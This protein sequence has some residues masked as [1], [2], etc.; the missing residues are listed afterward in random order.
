MNDVHAVLVPLPL[1]SPRPHQLSPSA[2]LKLRTYL[3]SARS[4][5]IGASRYLQ[6]GNSRAYF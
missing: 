5:A 4:S 2:F 1:R 6:K 3:T